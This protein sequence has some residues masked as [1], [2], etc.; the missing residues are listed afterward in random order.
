PGRGRTPWREIGEALRDI[1]YTGAVVM[2][3]FV[4]MG[5]QVGSDIKI[6]REMNPGADD[7]QLDLD[8]KNAVTF[9]RYML[10]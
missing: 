5:G 3:P 2:E 9:Q 4:R 1:G 6:W 10:D 7:A 8:A